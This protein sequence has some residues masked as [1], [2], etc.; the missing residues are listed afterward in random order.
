M[1]M[2][3]AGSQGSLESILRQSHTNWSNNRIPV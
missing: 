1:A 3:E 2:M